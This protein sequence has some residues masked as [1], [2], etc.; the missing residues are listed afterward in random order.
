M[1]GPSLK[2][3]IELHLKDEI[4]S[5]PYIDLTLWT[6]T[7]YGAD[8]EWTDVDTITVRPKPYTEREFYIFH[9]LR[10]VIRRCVVAIVGIVASF[11]GV[12]SGGAIG[13][14]NLMLRERMEET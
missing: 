14:L 12:G 5:R 11:R 6:M 4:V 2:N 10:A 7:E 9:I 3:G 13:I 8:V 1:I